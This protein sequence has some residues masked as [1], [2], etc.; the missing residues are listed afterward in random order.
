MEAALS[1]TPRLLKAQA[2]QQFALLWRGVHSI[3]L[4]KPNKPVHS[5]NSH[6]AI[7]LMSSTG[8]AVCSEGM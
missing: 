1:V 2:G 8:K 7:A 6:R 5:V 4:I 3:A